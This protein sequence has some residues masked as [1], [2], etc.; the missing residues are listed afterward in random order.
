MSC[1]VEYYSDMGHYMRRIILNSS[2][3]H[4]QDIFDITDKLTEYNVQPILYTHNGITTRH[5]NVINSCVSEIYPINGLNINII[6]LF[7]E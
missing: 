7:K 1:V 3:I 4:D 6:T 5:F 2:L